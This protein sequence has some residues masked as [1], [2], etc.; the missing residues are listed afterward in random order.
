MY[1][2]GLGVLL[3]FSERSVESHLQSLQHAVKRKSPDRR[4]C[5]LDEALAAGPDRRG[6]SCRY[7][8]LELDVHWIALA[9]ASGG[10]AEDSRS[11]PNL[12]SQSLIFTNLPDES[13][14][15]IGIEY[16]FGRCGAF[17]SN[18]FTSPEA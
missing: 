13:F 4:P 1:A 3:D 18:G 11:G 12:A 16:G 2:D 6:E 5:R 8:L 10:R 14:D 9:G 15:A 7:R 17:E